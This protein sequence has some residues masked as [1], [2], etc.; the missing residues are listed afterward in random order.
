[1]NTRFDYNTFIRYY[2]NPANVTQEPLPR[3]TVQYFD[4]NT[5]IIYDA[6]LGN[7]SVTVN[8]TKYYIRQKNNTI[9]F[10][11]LTTIPG[12]PGWWDVHY[13]F[14]IR[15]IIVNNKSALSKRQLRQKQQNVIYFHKTIQQPHL[16]TK[17]HENCYFFTDQ[18]IYDVVLIPDIDC[19][20]TA[21]SKMTKNFKLGRDY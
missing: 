1:M 16:R 18:P 15:K 17:K 9:L 7:T 13:H 4:G 6:S 14:G 3:P 8:G 19:L 10:S 12:Y 21:N 5:G 20:E 2:S 11:L